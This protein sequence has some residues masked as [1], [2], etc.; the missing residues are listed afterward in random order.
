MRTFA[1]PGNELRL[2]CACKL[3]LIM[4]SALEYKREAQA[5]ESIARAS[6]SLPLGLVVYRRDQLARPSLQDGFHAL[7]KTASSP[8]ATRE[9]EKP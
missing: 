4:S 2:K 5:S 6:L 3:A 9:D 7:K 1:Q 8:H